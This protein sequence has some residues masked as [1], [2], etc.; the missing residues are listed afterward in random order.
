MTWLSARLN[1]RIQFM[2]QTQVPVDDG[3]IR[4][5]YEVIVPKVWAGMVPVSVSAGSYV[6]NVQVADAP[7]HKFT[8]RKNKTAG[9]DI[10]GD[11]AVKTDHFVF[12]LSVN[13]QTTGRLFRILTAMNVEEKDEYIE[14]LAK[15]MGTLDTTR[16][17]LI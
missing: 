17:V 3:G 12:L 16:G 1:R 2:Q 15:E 11:G 4:Q 13:A 6:R 10:H 14:F 7:T 5:T 9:V 8:V